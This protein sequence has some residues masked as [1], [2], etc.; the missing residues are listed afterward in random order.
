MTVRGAF[1]NRVIK[2]GSLNV[3]G[4]FFVVFCQAEAR[5]H[6]KRDRLSFFVRNKETRLW[7]NLLCAR[8]R[9]TYRDQ[10]PPIR[11]H[12]NRF[13]CTAVSKT[14]AADDRRRS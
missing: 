1:S 12:F 7:L 6:F 14:Y 5:V 9:E 2:D 8:K 11:V 4:W 10:V 3:I 13:I